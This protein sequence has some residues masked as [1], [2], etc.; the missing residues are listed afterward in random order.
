MKYRTIA[1]LVGLALMLSL[2]GCSGN[3]NQTTEPPVEQTEESS[4]SDMVKIWGTITSADASSLTVDNQSGNSSQGEII[5][6]IDPEQHTVIDAVTG[7]PVALEEVQPGSFEAYLGPAMTMS[8]PPQTAPLMVI[9]NIPEDTQA[10]QYAVAAEAPETA[11]GMMTLRSTDGSTYQIPEDVEITPF[12]TKNIVRLEDIS[13][14][15]RCLIWQDA[16][17]IAEK[18]VLFQ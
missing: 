17:G 18:V 2:S 6:T 4:V 16:D 3:T 15:S 11:D 8:L 7:F 13:E 14:G 9:V 5:L 10:P 12:L 1:F